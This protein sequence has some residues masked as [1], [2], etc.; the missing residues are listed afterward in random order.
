MLI[1]Y[2]KVWC[3][4]YTS[5]FRKPKRWTK[6][7]DNLLVRIR[8]SD[9]WTVSSTFLMMCDIPSMAVFCRESIESC[10]GIVSRYFCKLLLTIPMAPMITGMTKYF[11]FHILWISTL[12]FLYFNFFFQLPFVLH[13]YLMALLHKSISRFCPSC[14]Y[15][16]Y[17]HFL[18][19]VFFLLWYFCSWVSGEPHHSGFKS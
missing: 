7:E 9:T 19:Q 3:A 11:M 18:S 5:H 15:Y 17:H 1:S 8:T 10:P 16:Y 14:C 2:L 6:T 4:E 12:R 13:S